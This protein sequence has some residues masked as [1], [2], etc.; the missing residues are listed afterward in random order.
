MLLQVVSDPGD[1]SRRLKS[2][3]KTYSR[4]LTDSGV[5]LLRARRRHLRADAALLR[6]AL[7][8]ALV[9]QRVETR[10]E[11][12][13]RRLIDLV[14]SALLYKLVK[15]RHGFL[16]LSVIKKLIRAR[17]YI[18]MSIDIPLPNTQHRLYLIETALSRN[19]LF[20][21]IFSLLHKNNTHKS[22]LFARFSIEQ[23]V[24]MP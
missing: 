10:L 23:S 20:T 1:I 8:D 7:V 14:M 24:N 13:R 5:R 3:R 16:L 12:R 15:C 18:K 11:H 2:V 22:D 9:L 4:D 6:R 19:F 21:L 17:R